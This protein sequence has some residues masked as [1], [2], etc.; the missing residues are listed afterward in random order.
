MGFDNEKSFI[1]A[2][3]LKQLREEKGLSHEKLSKV[4]L[5]QYDVKI[6]SDSLMNYEV[7]DVNH[8]KVGKNQGMRVEYLRCLAG[9]Y[10]VTADYL[11]GNSDIRSNNPDVKMIVD[12]TGL[13]ETNA[14]LIWA[15]HT[16]VRATSNNSTADPQDYDRATMTLSGL[17]DLEG[18]GLTDFCGMRRTGFEITLLVNDL[19][20]SIMKNEAMLFDYATMIDASR[21]V[22]NF[23]ESFDADNHSKQMEKGLIP[24]PAVE[25]V[26][27]ISNEMSKHIDRYFLE[28]Y[29][30]GN[31]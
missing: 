25:Y 16:V 19:I 17:L 21:H 14:N 26:R 4:L 5:D 20:A 9:F 18:Y 29:G 6:S 22:T 3:R 11:L 7:A 31:D 28:R 23:P 10:E 1:M 2:K 8:T 12:N 27:Y 24:I 30:Y 15:A 13:S